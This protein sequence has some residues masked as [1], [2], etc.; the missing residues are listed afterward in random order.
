MLAKSKIY[1]DVVGCQSLVIIEQV[2]MTTSNQTV[3]GINSL[4]LD[5]I[6]FQGQL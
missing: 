5:H 3:I 6:N 1:A 2:F 4:V